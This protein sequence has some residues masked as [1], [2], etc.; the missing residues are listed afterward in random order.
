[1]QDI[2]DRLSQDLADT[3]WRDIEPHAKRDA[4]IVVHNSLDMVEVGVAFAQDNVTSVQHWID[5]QLIQKPTPEQLTEWNN[6]PEIEFS[7][8]IVQPFVLITA[9]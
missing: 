8:L 6:Q 1:M 4:V 7:T 2:K 3:Q 9:Q 5:E